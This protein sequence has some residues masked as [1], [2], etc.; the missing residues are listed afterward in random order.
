MYMKYF[1]VIQK[2]VA[3]K[4]YKE[5]RKYWDTVVKINKNTKS[6]I[7]QLEVLD[8]KLEKR[9]SGKDLEKVKKKL[10][11]TSITNGDVN[12]NTNVATDLNDKTDKEKLESESFEKKTEDQSYH[13]TSNKLYSLIKEKCTSFFILDTRPT[14][15]YQTSHVKIATSINVPEAILSP[16]AT[17]RTI[18]KNLTIESRDQWSRQGYIKGKN[19]RMTHSY[20]NQKF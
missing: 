16:G 20:I 18:A 6:V 12:G 9:Y 2:I 10:A 8:E 19:A 11:E 13:V 17:Q 14:P 5:D 7:E 15:D 3:H 1:N 4:E